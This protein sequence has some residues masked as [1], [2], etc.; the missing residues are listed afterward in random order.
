MS[1]KQEKLLISYEKYP[2]LLLLQSHVQLLAT[3]MDY[4]MPGFPVLHYPL[5]LLKLMSIELVMLSNNLIPCSPFSS[6]PGSFPA[7]GSFLVSRLFASGG[8]SIGAS[9]SASALPMNIH[10]WFPLGLTLLSKGLWRVFSS[11]TVQKHEYFGAQPKD[12]GPA[13]TSIHGYCKNHSFDYLDLCHQSDVS[14]FK[15]AI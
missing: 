15:Y 7:S 13:L 1:I 8:Q 10:G 11:T 6:C 14:A 12:Y 5:S 4:S 9:A 3:P 2:Q